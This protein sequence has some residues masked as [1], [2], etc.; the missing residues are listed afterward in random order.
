MSRETLDRLV[1]V[2]LAIATA[3]GAVGLILIWSA[4]VEAMVLR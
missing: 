1:V 3:A 4:F 2:L